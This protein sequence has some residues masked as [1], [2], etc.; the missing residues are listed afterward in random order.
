MTSIII[1][2]LEFNGADLHYR[3]ILPQLVYYNEYEALFPRSN[4]NEVNIAHHMHHGLHF[5]LIQLHTKA[6]LLLGVVANEV[7]ASWEGGECM[8]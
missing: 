2:E 4:S 7:Q 5:Q 6:N 1:R 8:V 3:S